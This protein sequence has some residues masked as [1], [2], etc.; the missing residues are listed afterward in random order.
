[1]GF[2]GTLLLV[3][4]AGTVQAADPHTPVVPPARISNPVKESDLAAITLTEQAEQRLGIVTALVEK[5]KIART[6][7]FGGDVVLPLAPAKGDATNTGVKFAPNPPASSAEVLR[8]AEMQ[9]LADGEIQK[10]RV[11]LEAAR[12]S[13][14]RAE[15]LVRSETG[16]QRALDDARAALQLAQTTLDNARSRRG[17]LGSP[18]A[19]TSRLER[20]WVRVP[21]YVGY[22]Q[23]LDPA[24]EARVGGLTD[25]PGSPA[26]NA[27]FAAAP[28]LAN[29]GAAT[30]DWCYELTNA[31]QSL[32]LGQRVGVT[33][34]LRGEDESLVA[35][36]AAVLHD[37]HG[38]QWVYEKTGERTYSRRRV[39]IAQVVDGT[40]IVSSGLKQGARV[41]TD[42]A[43]E[44]FG[45]EFGAGK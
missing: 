30:V 22:L 18:V 11:Q 7:F 37:I 40:A 39:Q 21:V 36:W 5:R 43:A 19:E 1:M 29:P 25:R 20:V 28:L 4:C 9:A 14:E 13:A 3:L 16:S 35:P 42:G 44:L 10:A 24:K 17:L 8:L 31:D 45:T 2:Y 32:R 33:L 38:G 26:R 41:V 12:T 6:R 23:E 34:S 15:K 27:R